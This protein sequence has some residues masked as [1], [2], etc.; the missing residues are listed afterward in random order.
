MAS[1]HPSIK[2]LYKSF[3]W[4]SW[5]AE[6]FIAETFLVFTMLSGLWQQQRREWIP[7][8]H[9]KSVERHSEKL[10]GEVDMGVLETDGCG[11]TITHFSSSKSKDRMSSSWGQVKCRL[12]DK[13]LFLWKPVYMERKINK[14]GKNELCPGRQAE[15]RMRPLLS[16]GTTRTMTRH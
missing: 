13:C 10:F 4:R 7:I 3:G 6:D 9:L 2:T 5:R 16:E 15:D 1:I 11:E 8:L 14:E 12:M